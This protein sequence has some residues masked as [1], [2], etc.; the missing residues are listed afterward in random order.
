[1]LLNL[2]NIIAVLTVV[3]L[4]LQIALLMCGTV[5]KMTLSLRH[6]SILLNVV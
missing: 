4:V 1:M 2:V 3:L 5:Y 6:R